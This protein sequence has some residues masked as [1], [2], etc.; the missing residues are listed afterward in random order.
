[1]RLHRVGIDNGDTQGLRSTSPEGVEIL[2]VEIVGVA[3]GAE[4]YKGK[5][6]EL[7]GQNVRFCFSGKEL[8]GPGLACGS[9]SF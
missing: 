3:V 6:S 5:S 8:L 7:L 1:M 9:L 4:G 2:G